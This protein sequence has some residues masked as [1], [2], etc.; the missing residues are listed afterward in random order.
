MIIHNILSLFAVKVDHLTGC[1][2]KDI[3]L[4]LPEK[5]SYS[6]GCGSPT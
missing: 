2:H 1:I 6:V 3:R 4:V 5:G